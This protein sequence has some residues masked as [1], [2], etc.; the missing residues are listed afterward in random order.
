MFWAVVFLRVH[1]KAEL[2]QGQTESRQLCDYL[3]VKLNWAYRFTKILTLTF[4]G[5]KNTLCFMFEIFYLAYFYARQNPGQG[6]QLSS[7][8]CVPI[9]IA[10]IHMLP[11]LGVCERHG[12]CEGSGWREGCSKFQV[13]TLN[14][15]F[16]EP[17]DQ[18]GL[19]PPRLGAQS[20]SPREEGS[21]SWWRISPMALPPASPPAKL[22][23]L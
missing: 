4:T 8:T 13:D 1:L 15:P 19:C 10:S 2:C 23:V 18:D 3:E 17:W 9:L 12:R 11:Q 5:Q 7:R 20:P 21:L 6:C 16:W 14:R 22:L